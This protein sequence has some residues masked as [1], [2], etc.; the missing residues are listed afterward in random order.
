MTN[1]QIIGTLGEVW[2]Q[3]LFGG[4]LSEDRYDSTRDLTQSD[5][6]SVEIKTQQRWRKRGAFTVQ[7][8]HTANLHKCM[9]VDRLIFIEYSTGPDIL[10]WECTDR[11]SAYAATTAKGKT[12]ICWPINRMRLLRTEYNPKLAELFRKFSNT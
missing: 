2:Y 3:A 6:C 8:S 7:C 12:M 1:N 4:T 5:G 9:N 10:I 11:S